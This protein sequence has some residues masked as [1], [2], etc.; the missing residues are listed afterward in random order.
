MINET[1]KGFSLEKPHSWHNPFQVRGYEIKDI[2]LFKDGQVLY[3]FRWF[4]VGEETRTDGSKFFYEWSNNVIKEK[5]VFIPVELKGE[6]KRTIDLT[7]KTAFMVNPPHDRYDSIVYGP[8][9]RDLY[10]PLDKLRHEVKPDYKISDYTT[11]RMFFDLVWFT[12]LNAG[13]V[14]K[15][16][17]EEIKGNREFIDSIEPL[18]DLIAIHG[19]NSCH[20]ISNRDKIKALINELSDKFKE[21]KE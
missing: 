20:V 15:T 16:R 18:Y 6:S 5:T 14:A 10:I 4:N 13:V 9:H 2:K 17:E 12:D 11:T 7:S 1:E 8:K 3:S 19:F 21:V